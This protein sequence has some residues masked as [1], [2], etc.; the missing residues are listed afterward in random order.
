MMQDGSLAM[1]DYAGIHLRHTWSQEYMEIGL[2]RSH[3]GWHE[4]WFYVKSHDVAPIPAF[5]GSI[6]EAWPPEWSRGPNAKE[7]KKLHGLLDVITHLKHCG[8]QS[9]RVIGA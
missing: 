3:R 2:K 1:I 5:T 8:L 4:L 7:K 9:I 6:F